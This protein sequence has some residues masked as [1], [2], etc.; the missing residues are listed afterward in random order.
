MG[1]SPFS[2]ITRRKKMKKHYS[3]RRHSR[4]GPGAPIPTKMSWKAFRR[5]AKSNEIASP[6]DL[7]FGYDMRSF[8]RARKVETKL[9]GVRFNNKSRNYSHVRVPKEA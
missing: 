3:E 6:R 9:V 7:P 5:W 2:G 8:M 1:S 4:V